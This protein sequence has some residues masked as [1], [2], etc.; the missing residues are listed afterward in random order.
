MLRT[1]RIAADRRSILIVHDRKLPAE[2]VYYRHQFFGVGNAWPVYGL[3]L[4]RKRQNLK[5]PN[6]AA[7]AGHFAPLRHA[8][9]ISEEEKRDEAK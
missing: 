3:A 6:N 8:T 4:Q 5:S 1:R 2:E 9:V 7:A